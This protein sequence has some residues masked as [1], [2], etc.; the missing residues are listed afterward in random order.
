MAKRDTERVTLSLPRD[1]LRALAEALA[2]AVECRLA[3][4]RG[5]A[6]DVQIASEDASQ[7]TEW[8]QVA[9]RVRAEAGEQ[10]GR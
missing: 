1:Q 3:E 2:Y 4:A 6:N 10:E 5:K 7:I 8:Q 9:R